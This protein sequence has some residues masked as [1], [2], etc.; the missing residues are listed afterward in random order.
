MHDKILIRLHS[1]NNSLFFLDNGFTQN[2]MSVMLGV[3]QRTVENRLAEYNMTNIQRFSNIDDG[4]L[5]VYVQRIVAHFPRSGWLFN[6]LR[7][8]KLNVIV[9]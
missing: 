2:E 9:M 3:S 4:S 1:L 6:I 8:I 7:E 5:D